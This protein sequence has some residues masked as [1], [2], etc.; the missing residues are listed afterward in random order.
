MSDPIII[1]IEDETGPE[2]INPGTGSAFRD[3][4][5]PFQMNADQMMDHLFGQQPAWLD[6]DFIRGMGDM[7]R[8]G[9][10]PNNA[11]TENRREDCPCAE[12][13][14]RI[15]Q[16]LEGLPTFTAAWNTL[17]GQMNNQ[18]PGQ[19]RGQANNANQFGNIGQQITNAIRQG[20]ATIN[21]AQLLNN[22]VG[23]V[24]NGITAFG[25]IAGGLTG[26]IT[27]AALGAVLTPILGP[28]GPIIGTVIGTIAGESISVFFNTISDG[29]EA[30]FS[31]L[32]R[33]IGELSFF[34]PEIM[35]GR[36]DRQMQQLNFQINTAQNYGKQFAD[37]YGAQTDLI[38]ALEKMKLELF[39]YFGPSM[40]KLVED[41]S[42]LVEALTI[43]GKDG[44]LGP[45]AAFLQGL[46]G[47]GAFGALL[48]VL[49]FGF[50]DVINLMKEIERKRKM[51]KDDAAAAVNQQLMNLFGWNPR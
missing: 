40:S 15:I 42:L 46:L 29:I 45:L 4:N 41:A 1:K 11:Q 23:A 19:G 36:V 47:Q 6:P 34:S 8:L 14:E 16:I 49:G 28:A 31:Y 27:T 37:I 38:M 51:E 5:D 21:T 25:N 7:D 9:F 2:T 44:G 33:Q 10:E 20:V 12:Y 17:L 30:F 26:T 39:A 18:N 43:I 13:F 3:R 35:G 32:D 50:E 22:P 48:K 24:T